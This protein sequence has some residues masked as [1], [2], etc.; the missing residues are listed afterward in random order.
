MI[1][2]KRK[3]HLDK[4]AKA[5]KGTKHTEEAKRKMRAAHK[6]SVQSEETKRKI[7]ETLKRRVLTKEHKEKIRQSMIGRDADW[8]KKEK[9]HKWKGGV[10]SE[11]RLIRRSGEYKRWRIAVF[12][13]DS[14]TCKKCKGIGGDLNAHHVE[15]FADYPHIRLDLDNGVTLCVDCH[16]EFHNIYG[17]RGTNSSQW[18]EYYGN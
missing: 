13:R 12:E 6:G 16:K 15:N 11:V 4:L 7:S 5:N 17:D 3:K 2:E 1:S 10:T 14:Y 9:N 8:M 18:K